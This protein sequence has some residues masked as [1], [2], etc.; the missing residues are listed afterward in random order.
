M[1]ISGS[2]TVVASARAR[3]RHLP[4]LDGLRGAAV[5]AVLLYHFPT[6]RFVPGGW[7]GVD[8]F[9]VL[10]G[11]LITALLLDRRGESLR[12][13]YRRRLRR[14]GPA[15]A[16]FVACWAVLALVFGRQPW[17]HD[18]TDLAHIP[19]VTPGW[20]LATVLAGASLTYNWWLLAGAPLRPIGHM[21]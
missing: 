6:A 13:F 10:S 12:A 1:P 15:A 17:F 11:F 18:R 8:V 3:L 14:L 7:V 21:W 5:L 2:V 20:V 9:F 19:P 4:A 16:A